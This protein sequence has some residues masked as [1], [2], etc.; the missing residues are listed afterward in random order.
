MSYI[1]GFNRSTGDTPPA[2]QLVYEDETFVFTGNTLP[3]GLTVPPQ[4]TIWEVF[5]NGVRLNYGAGGTGD[6][7]LSGSSIVFTLPCDDDLIIVRHPVTA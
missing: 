2:E 1:I 5:R 4:P 6:W 7:E 3:T